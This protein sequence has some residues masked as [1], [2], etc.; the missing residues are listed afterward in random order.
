MMFLAVLSIMFQLSSN[1]VDVRTRTYVKPI[2]IVDS[3][4]IVQSVSDNGMSSGAKTLLDGKFGQT[5]ERGW[6]ASGRSYG[7]ILTNDG[8]KAGYV[9]LDFGEELYGGVSL[10]CGRGEKNHKLRIRFGESVAEAMSELGERNSLND[11]SVRDTV[12]EAPYFGSREIGDTGFRFV[13]IDLVTQGTVRIESVRA[14]SVMRPMK[15]CG[16]F[17]CSD[18]R[19]NRIWDTAVRTVHLCCQNYL[20]DGIKRDRLVWM[21]DM[22]P[23][24][25]AL[26]TAFGA[27]D[28]IP[29]SLD[30]A[31]ATTRPDEWMN[32]MPTYTLWWIR[33]LAEWY[34]YTGDLAYLE[35]HG[36]YLEHTFDHVTEWMTDGVW[37]AGNFL[38]WPTRRNDA[39]AT[40]GTQGLALM[41]ARETEFLARALKRNGLAEKADGMARTLSSGRF[42]PHGA[43]TAAA[44]LS[45]SGLR[46]VKEMYRGVLSKNGHS[47]VSTFYGYYMLEAMGNAGE[48]ERALSTVRDYWGGMLDVGATSFWEDFDLSWTN[49]CFRIDEL[50]V[51]GKRDIHGDCGA[52]CYRGFRHSLCHGWSA[53]P[54]A[55]LMTHVLGVRIVD[56]GCKT[57]ELCPHLG[58]L[59]WVE[60]V[61]PTP[62]GDVEILVRRGEDGKM[63][64]RCNHPDGMA[65]KKSK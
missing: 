10:A 59:S 63:S 62:L 25:M 34:R 24:T 29:E 2:R 16:R 65:V 57:I 14:V 22:H 4:G 60:G 7:C 61:F 19:I 45:L 6:G 33:N 38:D 64:V 21:G 42:D 40:A 37:T 20:W 32:S 1:S 15:R 5:P 9:M 49:N 51:S 12:L 11:H 18:D 44:M 28:I 26:L 53:G 46:D 36:D 39:A 30:Y 23:E 52:F 56:V 27:V 54:A 31:A 43:K 13:R 3:D 8:V 35:K 55:W 47:G 50:P 58:D 41:T 48:T 17:R